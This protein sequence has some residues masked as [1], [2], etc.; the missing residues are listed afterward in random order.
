MK[1]GENLMTTQSNRAWTTNELVNFS[2]ALGSAYMPCGQGRN[3]TGG[4][5]WTAQRHVQ[6]SAMRGQA[7]L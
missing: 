2:N 4:D 7:Y 1:K 5:R 6:A 3:V